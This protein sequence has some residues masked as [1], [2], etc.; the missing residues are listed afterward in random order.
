MDLVGPQLM[1]GHGKAGY[2]QVQYISKPEDLFVHFYKVG[3]VMRCLF[4][5][6]C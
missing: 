1:T 5:V 2:E 6:A 4:L 3:S